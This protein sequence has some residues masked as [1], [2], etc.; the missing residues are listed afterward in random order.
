MFFCTK[1]KKDLI[2]LKCLLEH[3]GRYGNGAEIPMVLC[4]G[5]VTSPS[6]G[7]EVAAGLCTRKAGLAPEFKIKYQKINDTLLG[8]L[9]MTLTVP[10]PFPL[11]RTP[12]QGLFI[13][14]L[15]REGGFWLCD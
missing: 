10:I 1:L 3:R 5:C 13:W 12:K 11:Q 8:M 4:P 2:L 6:K 15:F 14:P 9:R 7:M